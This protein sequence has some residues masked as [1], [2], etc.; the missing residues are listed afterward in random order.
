MRFHAAYV[1]LIAATVVACSNAVAAVHRVD[2]RPSDTDSTIVVANEP[3]I[4]L[5]NTDVSRGPLLIFIPG[6]GGETVKTAR[7]EK[8]FFETALSLGYRVIVLSYV[9][10]PAISQVC[11]L[12]TVISD[13]KCAEHVRQ[14]RIFGDNV[15]KLVNDGPQDAIVH[16]LAALLQHLTRS[17]PQGHWDEYLEANQ[18]NWSKM[19]LSG[20]SQGGGMAAFI[21]KRYLAGGVI[22]FSGGWDIQSKNRIASWY[23]LSGA[24]PPDRLYGTYHVKEKFSGLIRDS[25]NAMRIPQDHQFALDKPLRNPDAKNPGHAEGASNPVYLD[26]WREILDKLKRS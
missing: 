13:P 20:Q 23:A 18:L 19:V 12:E 26:V 7:I 22:D 4:A 16:R 24:T 21:A 10:T 11:T 1:A 2:V 8:D 25:Y 14:K 9:D 3:H 17:D 15:T 6:T 5:R